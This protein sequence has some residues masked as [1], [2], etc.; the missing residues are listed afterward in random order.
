MLAYI[1]DVSRDRSSD[2]LGEY[3]TFPLANGRVGEAKFV[4]WF[5]TTATQSLRGDYYDS[6]P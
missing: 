5:K 2:W 6:R 4:D 3:T 1:L